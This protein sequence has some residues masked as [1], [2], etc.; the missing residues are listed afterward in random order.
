LWYYYGIVWWWHLIIGKA[1]VVAKLSSDII[2]RSGEL[3]Y[4]QYL[5]C[6]EMWG[7][8][9]NDIANCDQYWYW[10]RWC[11]WFFTVFS[12]LTIWG[13]LFLHLYLKGWSLTLWY[14]WYYV[15]IMLTIEVI[16]FSDSV[17]LLC[18]CSIVYCWREWWLLRLL[19][20][21]RCCICRGERKVYDIRLFWYIFICIDG[22]LV[23][24]QKCSTKLLIWRRIVDDVVIIYTTLMSRWCAILITVELVLCYEMMEEENLSDHLFSKLWLSI[25]MILLWYIM[26]EGRRR[27]MC[28]T[29]TILLLL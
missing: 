26:T 1:N 3:K 28:D 6:D 10:Y 24:I 27:M 9:G 5:T 29:I 14:Y 22:I 4:W 25:M 21:R 17:F 8:G 13:K 19:R 12:M 18:Y 20:C 2:V 15:S 23:K 7:V 11:W 16:V